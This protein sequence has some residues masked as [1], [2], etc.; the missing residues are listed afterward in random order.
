MDVSLAGTLVVLNQ[1][2]LR[3]HVFFDKSNRTECFFFHFIFDA[4][5]P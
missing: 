2:K 1:Q 5:L 3:Q 4:P